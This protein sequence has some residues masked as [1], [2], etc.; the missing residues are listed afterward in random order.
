MQPYQD[1]YG[2]SGNGYDMG[3][4]GGDSYSGDSGSYSGGGG[5]GG[6]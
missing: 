4:S 2:G 1:S 5:G 3:N 6:Y